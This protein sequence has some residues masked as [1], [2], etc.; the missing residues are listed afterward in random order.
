MKKI[1]SLILIF[2]LCFTLVGCGNDSSTNNS[3]NNGGDTT[4][5]ND[6][7]NNNTNSDTGS[8][9][10]SG[11]LTGIP[12]YPGTASRSYYPYVYFGGTGITEVLIIG[13]SIGEVYEYVKLLHQN[14]W[15]STISDDITQE[16]MVE[17]FTDSF[18]E[19]GL[20][21]DD[22]QLDIKKKTDTNYT[23]SFYRN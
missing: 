12:E 7:N 5:E 4:N 11:K 8:G 1:L 20:W 19:F 21:K 15:D 6:N 16:A 13:S 18:G 3:N 10:P 22:L 23:L 9:W 17:R 14:G 2:V